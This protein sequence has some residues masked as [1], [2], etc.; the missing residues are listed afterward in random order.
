MRTVGRFMSAM[1]LLLATIGAGQG[2]AEWTTRAWADEADTPTDRTAPDIVARRIDQPGSVE[3][4]DAGDA[5]T[6]LDVDRPPEEEFVHV[7]LPFADL[8]VQNTGAARYR[9]DEVLAS[10]VTVTNNGPTIATG[11]TLRVTFSKGAAYQVAM[12][13]QGTCAPVQAVVTC[14]LG[15]I[16]PRGTATVTIQVTPIVAYLVTST[17]E[18]AGVEIDPDTANNRATHTVKNSGEP[19]VV[20]QPRTLY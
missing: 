18:V 6:A 12:P 7:R 3:D 11:T 2:G 4:G 19:I 5:W 16:P 8:A 20:D 17:A 1:A 9:I 14:D 15:N 10:T 13:S